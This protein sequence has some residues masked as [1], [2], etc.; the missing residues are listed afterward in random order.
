MFTGLLLAILI[1][2]GAAAALAGGIVVAQRRRQLPGGSEALALPSGSED[3]LLERTIRDLRTG[4]ILTYDGKDYV[5]EGVVSY[6]EDGHRW[7]AGRIVD[8]ADSRWVVVG[9]ERGGSFIVRM[10]T[11]LDDFEIEGYPPEVL[12]VGDVRFTIDKR[13]TATARMSGETGLGRGSHSAGGMDTVERCRW[14]LYDTPGDDTLIVEQWSDEYR[15]LR[16][17]KVNPAFIELMPGS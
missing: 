4:D 10:A 1:I 17:T 8:G 6:D 13:G 12:L 3:R 11:V 9:M 14:W 7:L 2:T 5:V 16:G 15:V